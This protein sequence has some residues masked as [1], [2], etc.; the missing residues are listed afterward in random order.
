MSHSRFP[1]ATSLAAA[2]ALA[3]ALAGC[4]GGDD[5]CG[6]GG[7]S[8]IGLIADSSAVILTYGHLTGGLNNDCPAADAPSGVISMSIE[9]TQQGGEGRITLCIGRPDL[10][11]MQSLALGVDAAAPVRVIDLAGSLNNCT[12]T[13]D[14]AQPVVGTSHASGLCDNGKDPSGFA[15]VTDASL[16]LTRTCGTVVDSTPV[17]LHGRVAVATAIAFR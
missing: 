14:R 9:G 1:S 5:A 4:G 11:G 3:G 15:L 13:I 8:D 16:S 7:A 2:G 10:L 6:T 17:I 12:Y